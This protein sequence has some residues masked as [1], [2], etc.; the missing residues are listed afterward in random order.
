MVGE[1][2]LLRLK[3][4]VKTQKQDFMIRLKCFYGLLLSALQYNVQMFYFQVY[5][6]VKGNH[7]NTM[8]TIMLICL[9]KHLMQ[10]AE[11]LTFLENTLF[12]RLMIDI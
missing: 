11:L 4:K 9:A 3:V 1:F 12:S 5:M 7:Y 8:P 6:K 10:I 2:P